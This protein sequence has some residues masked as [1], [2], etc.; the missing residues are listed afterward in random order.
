VTV[1]DL[2]QQPRDA[3]VIVSLKG[4]AANVRLLDSSGYSAYKAGRKHRYIGGLAKKSPV[5]LRIPR[6]GHWYLAVDLMGLAGK[7]QSSVAVEP[8]PLPPIRPSSPGSLG[9]I[10]HE[11]ASDVVPGKEETWDVFV[12]HAHE[13]KAEVAQPLA[14]A[15]Q[16]LGVT[17]WLDDTELRIGD[18]LRRKIDRALANSRFGIVILSR[19]FFAKD[20]PQ[21]ELDGLVT[22]SVSGEQTLLPL[23]HNITKDEVVK[24]SP[25]LADKLARSTAQYTIEEIAREIAEVVGE[26]QHDF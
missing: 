6:S 16:R 19:S 25:S 9:Q 22:R 24:Q 21:Y 26:Q 3:T 14:E 4:N 8:P 17:V 18:S 10:R 5:R 13:D 20:W 23:W 15:L 11:L 1:H 12:S 7:V 2:K